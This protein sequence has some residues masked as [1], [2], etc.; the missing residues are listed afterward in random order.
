MTDGRQV[1]R[2]QAGR[3]L[4]GLVGCEGPIGGNCH[5]PRLRVHCGIDTAPHRIFCF[6][7]ER[8]TTSG[9]WSDQQVNGG[10]QED[11]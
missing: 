3:E 2:R 5:L 11:G 9:V 6:D 10:A 8:V 7:C 4:H 1:A